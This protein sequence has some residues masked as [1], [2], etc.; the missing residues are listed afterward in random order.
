MSTTLANICSYAGVPLPGHIVAVDFSAKHLFSRFFTEKGTTVVVRATTTTK[1]ADAYKALCAIIAERRA[2]KALPA[3]V[4]RAIWLSKKEARR[5]ALRKKKLALRRANEKMRARQARERKASLLAIRREMEKEPSRAQVKKAQKYWA[6][7]VEAKLPPRATEAQCLLAKYRAWRNKQA[8][9]ACISSSIS[10][11]PLPLGNSFDSQYSPRQGSEGRTQLVG[12]EKATPRGVALGHIFCA[13]EACQVSCSHVEQ[14]QTPL[15]LFF[16]IPSSPLLAW[17]RIFETILPMCGPLYNA[18]FLHKLTMQLPV[19]EVELSLIHARFLKER[20]DFLAAYGTTSDT[21]GWF[22]AIKSFAAGFGKI[23]S[24]ETLDLDLVDPVVE[25]NIPTTLESFKERV[26]GAGRMVGAGALI[27]F[28]KA[29]EKLWDLIMKCFDATIGPW[30]ARAR[31][32]ATTFKNYLAQAKKWVEDAC[33]ACHTFVAAIKNHIFTVLCIVVFV[34]FITM[35]ERALYKVGVVSNVGQAAG[36]FLSFLLAYFGINALCDNPSIFY[37]MKHHFITLLQSCF[38]SKVSISGKASNGVS[39]AYASVSEMAYAPVNFLTSLGDSLFSVNTSTVAY[40]GK[41]GN[42]LEGIRKGI[43]CLKDASSFALE[44]LASIFYRVTGR[45]IE[46][47]REIAALTRHDL[48]AWIARVEKALLDLEVMKLR[49][50]GMLDALNLLLHEGQQIRTA[51][52]DS[53]GRNQLSAAY[54]RITSDLMKKLEEKRKEVVRAGDSVGRRMQPFWLYLYG[55]S[56]CGK[57][58]VMNFFA[59]ELLER[60]GRPPTDCLSL[61]PTDKY[62]SGYERQSCIK[63]DDLSCVRVLEGGIEGT[64]INMV[65]CQEWRPVMA[66]VS[67]KGM[68]FDSPIIV[69][70]SNHFD[71]PTDSNFTCRE[72]YQNRRN[73]VLEC[74]RACDADQVV[75]EPSL[76]MTTIM[77]RAVNKNDQSA[78]PGP[79]GQWQQ[80]IFFL[81]YVSEMMD[82]HFEQEACKQQAW[83]RSIGNRHPIFIESETVLLRENRLNMLGPLLDM[84]KPAIGVDGKFVCFPLEQ[85]TCTQCRES[86]FHCK[87]NSAQVYK[88]HFLTEKEVGVSAEKLEES[89]LARI[90]LCDRKEYDMF[91]TSNPIV[92]SFLRSLVQKDMRVEGV[93]KKLSGY[94]S[95]AQEDFWRELPLAEKAYL[96]LMQKRV[97]EIR[98]LPKVALQV[99][100]PKCIEGIRRAGNWLWENGAKIMVLLTALIVIYFAGQG[101]LKLFTALCCGHAGVE[102]MSILDTFSVFPS[103]SV[104]AQSYRARNTPLNYRSHTFSGMTSEFDEGYPI[105]LTVGI[106]TPKGQFISAIR[107]RERSLLLTQHQARLI[108]DRAKLTITYRSKKGVTTSFPIRWEPTVQQ[109]GLQRSGLFFFSDTEVCIYRHPSLSPLPSANESFFMDDYESFLR[110]YP[111]LKFTGLKLKQFGHADH[112]QGISDGT[113]ICHMWAG[114]GVTVHERHRIQTTQADGSCSYYNDLPRFISS[115]TPAGPEDCGTIVTTEIV[116]NNQ[117]RSVVVGMIVGGSV[118]NGRSKAVIAFIPP[119]RASDTYSS[120][121]YEEEAGDEEEGY[122]KLGAILDRSKRP[123]LPKKSQY[124]R[125]PEDLRLPIP[126]LKQPAILAK[127]DER[128][129]GT[130]HESFDPIRAAP[131][132]YAKPMQ[133]LPQELVEKVA[134]DIIS[135]WKAIQSIPLRKETL[136]V[137]INGIEGEDYLDRMVENTSEGYPYIL[138][139]KHGEKGKGRFLE[140]DPTDQTGYKK[141]LIPGCVIERDLEL[142]LRQSRESVPELV[143]ID[144]PKDELLPLRKIYDT[145]KTR[146]FSICPFPYN[147]ALRMYTLRLVQFLQANRRSLAAQVGIS[148]QSQDWD[149]LY[150]RLCSMNASEA[151]N[152]DYSGFDGY[153]N[154][155][156]VNVIARIM[157]AMYAGESPEDTA[158]RT[159]C[160]MALI[161]RKVIVDS[162]VYEVR[163]GLPSGLALT[164][165][166]N[167]IFNEILVRCAFRTIAPPLERNSFHK[168]IFLAV[169]GDDNIITVHPDCKY[170]NGTVIKQTMSE[171]GVT[172]TDGSDK[173]SLVLKPKPIHEIDFLKRSFV[174]QKEGGN[175]GLGVVAPLDKTAIMSCLQ[176][177]KP[178]GSEIDTL[179]DSVRSALYELRL[180]KNRAEYEAL[181]NFYTTNRPY[182][183]DQHVLPT[184]E[185]A[186]AL[187]LEAKSGSK[188]YVPHKVL[189][190]KLDI[191]KLSKDMRSH[192][193]TADW[194]HPVE[195]RVCVA[196]NK[197][198]PCDNGDFFFVSINCRNPVGANGIVLKPSYY[199]EGAG[200]LPTRLWAKGFRG[201]RMNG[202]SRIREAYNDGKT[203][204]F[205]SP[206]PY[207][208]AWVAAIFFCEGMNLA[209]PSQ[210][211]E[212]FRRVKSPGVNDLSFYFEDTKLPSTRDEIKFYPGYLDSGSRFRRV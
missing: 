130:K 56:H 48:K 19:D 13:F 96:R 76:P 149:N 27:G 77:C 61:T 25:G 40:F 36:S 171:W 128:L 35:C 119:Q 60:M 144:T 203:I 138:S 29:K 153:L 129:I 14:L 123:T 131:R 112:L 200:Q 51:M 65:S 206:G 125:V 202:V 201:T 176:Y 193:D 168:R 137:A 139:R 24:S 21:W 85:N 62:L 39:D 194:C 66:D 147:L 169:Y 107:G 97:D 64:L 30:C 42:S 141:R 207:T 4:K 94:V 204:V 100:M 26:K 16:S 187:H 71:A 86:G 11:S 205:Q 182:L 109:V 52:I 211:L 108:P 102:S 73:L 172:I 50:R 150:Q 185:E 210:L 91:C 79:F 164:V 5:Q 195:R 173:T 114:S 69:S 165:T 46:F 81:N 159:N 186:T 98:E 209:T 3:T 199:Y 104:D 183:R 166:M 118:E 192:G 88:G 6:T 126:E 191:P 177:Y 208:E 163:A 80:G 161:N 53:S 95:P 45:D 83:L 197:Y 167:S 190:F 140:P 158:V 37:D 68:L 160:I 115:Y 189:D 7:E 196:G 92:H 184:W 134:E 67:D 34:G 47:F 57:S 12:W 70:S 8:K 63:I 105:D 15:G 178:V 179:I 2:Y 157:N 143:C 148:P 31:K 74:R 43:N 55:G 17:G 124:V 32:I 111:E 117:P 151:Y 49:D 10:S 188:P 155:Q 9:K 154:A 106:T 75:Q 22:D 175:D 84:S 136:S 181:Y 156:I 135:D 133:E 82:T 90:R 152:C 142:L 59:A 121:E 170:F 132:K 18:D 113:P 44:S 54:L 198:S 58:N 174:T 116:V 89:Y 99:Y 1:L 101:F 20:E 93:D 180:H 162:Q 87:L 23:A 120:V 145:P 103:S 146:F 78:L 38:E 33:E 122:C 212:L 72:A 28:D 127:G 41:L 110:S